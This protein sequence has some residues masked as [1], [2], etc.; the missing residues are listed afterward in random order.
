MPKRENAAVDI[1]QKI[2]EI[3]KA[4]GLSQT[5]FAEK[6]TTLIWRL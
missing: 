3:R 6:R 4:E 5:E 2:Y 1:G